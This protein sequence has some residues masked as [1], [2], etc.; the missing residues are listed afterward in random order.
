MPLKVSFIKS[1]MSIVALADED[2]RRTIVGSKSLQNSSMLTRPDLSSSNESAGAEIE[3]ARAHTHTDARKLQHRTHGMITPCN[4]QNVPACLPTNEITCTFFH[5]ASV[6]A[7]SR[8]Q[9]PC[10]CAFVWRTENDVEIVDG[11]LQLNMQLVPYDKSQLLF[12]HHARVVQVRLRE[13]LDQ[14]C[15][16]LISTAIAGC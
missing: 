13:R 5:C 16:C 14:R 6:F 4:V 3:N 10:E 7:L 8:Q 2:A 9:A 11:V 12:V 1:S 15:A